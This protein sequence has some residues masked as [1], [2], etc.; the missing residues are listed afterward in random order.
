M[1][2]WDFR[3]SM[4]GSRW[5]YSCEY[6]MLK[7]F[8]NLICNLKQKLQLL[9]TR[10]SYPMYENWFNCMCKRAGIHNSKYTS[11]LYSKEST[12][13][14]IW[15][16]FLT[17]QAMTNSCLLPLLPLTL[18]GAV[19]GTVVKNGPWVRTMQTLSVPTIRMHHNSTWLGNISK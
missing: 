3:L 5:K 12:C 16:G 10:Y 19:F 15:V 4:K 18:V 14:D 7:V 17:S 1:T 2:G 6:C 8:C 9:C 13:P 11:A